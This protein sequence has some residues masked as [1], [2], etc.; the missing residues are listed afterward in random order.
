MH[1]T[2]TRG[3]ARVAISC[4]CTTGNAALAP[5]AGVPVIRRGAA[6]TCSCARSKSGP[7][8]PVTPAR[9]PWHDSGAEHSAQCRARDRVR[10]SRRPASV[11]VARA[12]SR[13]I[14]PAFQ[15]TRIDPV[16]TAILAL[17]ALI[18]N[19]HAASSTLAAARALLAAWLDGAAPSGGPRRASLAAGLAGPA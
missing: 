4:C 3:L 5:L 10:W 17:G 12:A 18:G 11:T 7:L 13:F 6:P 16:F 9:L 8:R 15:A 19:R 1:R 2:L 14:L